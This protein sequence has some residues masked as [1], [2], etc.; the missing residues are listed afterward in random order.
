M[1]DIDTITNT[2]GRWK[3]AQYGTTCW[4]TESTQYARNKDTRGY[5]QYQTNVSAPKDLVYSSYAQS[6][7]GSALLGKYDTI[8]DGGQVIEHTVS[9][10]QGLSDTF[11]WSVTEQLKIGVSVKANAGIPLI[12]GA[13]TTSTVEMDLSSTQG[14]S[15]TKSSNYGAST[16]VPISPHTHGWGEVDLSFTELRTQWVGNAS[17]VGCVAIWFNNKVALNNNGD[18][19]YLWF[20]PIQQVFSEIIQHN[21]ISTSGYV[22]QGG[23]VLAQATGTFHSS[24]GLSLKTISH[25]QPYPG[26]NKAVRTS[27]GYRRLDKPLES[28][29]FPAEHD[30]NGRSR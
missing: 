21:I 2:W 17:M 23:G 6:D 22:V 30:L 12:G 24:M 19:H 27:F 16:T 7:G 25:E 8:N 1:I 10:Q 28:V 13:E 4:F 20:I 11:T 14:A 26:D 29:V 18:Y 3:T 5:M 9:L 15:T